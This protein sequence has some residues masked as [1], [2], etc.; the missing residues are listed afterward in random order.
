MANAI[1]EMKQVIAHFSSDIS[2]TE[3]KRRLN[4]ELE[5]F[6]H[7]KVLLAAVTICKYILAN[8]EIVI[9]GSSYSKSKIA[10][11]DCILTYGYSS[12][13]L[14]ILLQAQRHVQFEVVVVDSRPHLKGKEM[15]EQLCNH[16]ISCTY[17]LINAVSFVMSRRVSKVLLGAHALLANG[18]V[19]SPIGINRWKYKVD[20][21]C[22]FE[23]RFTFMQS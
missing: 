17:V 13:V 19:M 4:D 21:I 11:G 16:N 20:A 14:H 7:E 1:K 10:N 5:T 22:Y 9:T 3:A 2:E 15:L 18:Y 23:M 6:V 12:L 8:S